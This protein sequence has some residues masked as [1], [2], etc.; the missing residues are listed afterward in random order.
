MV[1]SRTRYKLLARVDCIMPLATK[2]APQPGTD[3]KSLYPTG[4][5]C[6]NCAGESVKPLD[7]NSLESRNKTDDPTRGFV[8]TKEDDWHCYGI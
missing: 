6:L 7:M 4:S 3:C 8:G 5:D 2:F 1:V